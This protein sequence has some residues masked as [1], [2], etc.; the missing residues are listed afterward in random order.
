MDRRPTASQA[1]LAAFCGVKPPS[2]SAWFTGETKALKAASLRK[3]AEYLGCSRDWLETGVGPPG[4]LDAAPDQAPTALTEPAASTPPTLA[5][6]LPVLL[7]HLPGLSEYR[8]G[9]VIQAIAAA[10]HST[11]PLDQVESDLLQWLSE[12]RAAGPATPAPSVANAGRR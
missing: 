8:A 5:Q 1:G 10:A 2:V 12:P 4:W 9:Q 7:A 6:A 3:A 11:A